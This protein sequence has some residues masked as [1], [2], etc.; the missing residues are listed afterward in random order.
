MYEGRQS[1]GSYAATSRWDGR[2]LARNDLVG[3]GRNFS[4][5]IVLDRPFRSIGELGYA[6]RG[7][8]W[9]SID[10]FSG[11][12]GDAAL[13]DL[14]SVSEPS[15]TGLRAGVVNPNT[16]NAEVIDAVLSGGIKDESLLSGWSGA[17]PVALTPSQVG[18]IRDALVNL[19]TV[20]PLKNRGEMVTRFV[21]SDSVFPLLPTGGT[22]DD[23]ASVVKRRREAPVRA[24][25]DVSATR[26][27][28]LMIDVIVQAGRQLPGNTTGQGFLVESEKRYWVHLALDRVSGK[29]VD[30]IWEAVNE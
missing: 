26:T 24:L 14:F 22:A 17:K 8:V 7:D 29:V 2:S 19:T 20:S 10:F 21:G 11:N 9:K 6:F 12:S 23:D 4:R 13:L 25:V 18:K 5:P 30:S 3:G 15:R 16:H 1:D 28:N 27:W